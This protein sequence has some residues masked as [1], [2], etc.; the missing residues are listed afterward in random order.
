MKRIKNVRPPAGLTR[1]L[2]RM[3]ISCYRLKLGWLFGSRLLLLNHV[4]CVSGKPRETI[5]EVAEH[6][7]TDDSYVVASGWGPTA[8]WYRN[9][10]HTPEVSIQVGVR[11]IPV[12]AVLLE[13][14]EGADI[15]VRYASRHRTT[16]KYV[17]PR[18]LGF[19]V[20][21]SDA[22]FRAVGQQMPFVRFVPRADV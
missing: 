22:D 8:T 16:A 6:D 19:S 4:G 10:L 15:F 18:I 5:L 1:L 17:L 14:D 20:D 9:I 2:F 11:T 12:I 3:P 13:E 21:G 7:A